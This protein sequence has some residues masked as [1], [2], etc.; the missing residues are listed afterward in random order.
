MTLCDDDSMNKVVQIM[1]TPG[2]DP[3]PE[4]DALVQRFP[5][6]PRLHF[7]RG[8]NLVTLKRHIEAHEALTRAITLA[9]DFAIA[10]FQLGLFE[11][12]SGEPDRALETWGRL[13]RLPD[14]HY[15]RHFVD[16]LRAMI[17]DDFPGTIQHLR[18][19]M[20]LNQENPPL[21]HDMQLIIDT[22]MA[23]EQK[24]DADTAET[25]SE[26]SSVLRFFSPRKRRD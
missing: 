7:L 23:L 13:D 14:Q 1:Q 16:G 22:V 2:R 8:S 17:R 12:T 15:L 20:A 11:L 4:L 10:R 5:N 18:D 19:G 21:N 3:A 25:S 24:Q 26:T 9:P 6:D